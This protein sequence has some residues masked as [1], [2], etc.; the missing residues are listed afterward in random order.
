VAR[1]FKK[2][3]L[4]LQA[5]GDLVYHE[6]APAAQALSLFG[7]FNGW[8]RDQYHAQKDPFGHWKLTLKAKADGNPII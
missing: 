5:N 1:S 2:F 4:H 6:W 7:D 8:N 3:G